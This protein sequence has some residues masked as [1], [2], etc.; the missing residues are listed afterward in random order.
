MKSKKV[1]SNIISALAIFATLNG[2]TSAVKDLEKQHQINSD[3]N[4]TLHKFYA[5]TSNA[6]QLVEDVQGVLVCPSITKGGFLVGVESGI[7]SLQ[8]NGLTQSYYR[9]TAVTSGLLA[10]VKSYSMILIFN[11]NT[12]LTD[13]RTVDKDWTVDENFSIHVAKKGASGAIE[14]N[15]MEATA[16][17]YAFDETGLINEFSLEGTSFKKIVIFP[18]N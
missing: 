12:V 4:H 13:F 7:C 6:R 3:V 16:N 9:T 1:L 18:D 14:P 5:E 15:T 17:A 11:D 8:I 2:C 10:G